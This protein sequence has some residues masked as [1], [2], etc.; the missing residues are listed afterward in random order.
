MQ[1]GRKYRLNLAPEQA[2][3][4]AQWIGCARAVYNGKDAEERYQN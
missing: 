4:L 3:V 1:T 2:T